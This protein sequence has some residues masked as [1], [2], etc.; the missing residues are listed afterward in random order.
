MTTMTR[1]TT[2]L[3]ALLFAFAVLSLSVSAQTRTAEF[4]LRSP[5]GGTV[6]SDGLRGKVVVLAFG[7]SWLPLSKNQLEALK[8]ISEDYRGRS[9]AVY[10]VS[11]DSES[12]KSKNYASDEQ[13][14]NLARKY[15][16]SV[17]RDPDGQVSKKLGV[18]ELPSAVILDKQGNVSGEPIGGLDPNANLA[19]RLATEI[20][21]IL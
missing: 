6:R 20:D 12:A 2:V 21:K 10:W 19:A 18:N 7:A 4:S 15:K 5:D 8:K 14:S 11:T 9:V 16:V 3:V 17:L 1:R 13:L